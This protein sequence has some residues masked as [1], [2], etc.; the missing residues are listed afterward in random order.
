MTGILLTPTTAMAVVGDIC[1]AK[2][3]NRLLWQK[4][5]HPSSLGARC[6]I[7]N[8][9]FVPVYEGVVGKCIQGVTCGSEPLNVDI[10]R[11]K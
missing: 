9:S 6:M 1:Y 2:Q 4:L 7:Y 5:K 11:T 8:G 3:T 10:G